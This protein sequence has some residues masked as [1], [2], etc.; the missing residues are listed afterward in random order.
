LLGFVRAQLVI[1]QTSDSHG[2]RSTVHTRY[3]ASARRDDATVATC[4]TLYVEHRDNET[5]GSPSSASPPWSITLWRCLT[6]RRRRCDNGMVGAVRRN[7]RRFVVPLVVRRL[8][9]LTDVRK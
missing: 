7:C 2:E 9:V 1:D 4:E 5:A 8:L 3:C 6:T